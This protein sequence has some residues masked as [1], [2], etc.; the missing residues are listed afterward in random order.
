MLYDGCTLGDLAVNALGRY[1]ERDAVICGDRRQ[2]YAELRDQVARFAAV[3]ASAGLQPGDRVAI[4]ARN[5]PE[6]VAAFCAAYV[7]GLTL[8]PLSPHAADDDLV[9]VLQDA[10]I[11]CLLIDEIGIGERGAALAR[12]VASLRQVFTF[13]AAAFGRSLFACAAEVTPQ[14]LRSVALPDRPAVVGYT[15]GTTGKPKGVIQSQR[16]MVVA[17]QMMLAEWDWPQTPR[18]LLAT[19]LSHAAGVMVLPTLMKGGA[20]VMLPGFDPGAF[21]AEI[22]RS[23][24]SVTFLVPTMIYALLDAAAVGPARRLESLRTVFY[25]AAPM[26][27][28]R[29][30][31]AMAVFGPVFMQLY[32]QTEAP[33]CISTLRRDEHDL[34]RPE[35]L[36]SCGKPSAG[37]C[38]SLLDEHGKEVP[39]GA[40]GEICVRG[41]LVMESYHQRPEETAEVFRGGWLHTGDVGRFD[42]DGYLYIVDRCKDLII[43]GGLNVYPR[44]VESVLERHP[45]VAQCVVVGLPD[46]KWGEA[47]TAAVVC[48]SGHS[49]TAEDLAAFVRSEKSAL[50]AP[51]RIVF[52]ERLALTP[53]GKP[54]RAAIRRQLAAQSGSQSESQS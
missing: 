27:P 9:F 49:V 4:L 36:A 30:R 35:R 47:V 29:L 5:R 22:E 10:A 44:E 34:A 53:L 23:A 50:Y 43:T 2:S 16:G 24:V 1:P 26:A 21:L 28:E 15:G 39:T 18:M 20:I 42:D 54:D 11:D 13:G 12:R 51:K 38:V 31:Q 41:P 14:P 33:L 7:Q 17:H 32:G 3:F 40:I 46:P 19:P 6:V 8:T 52:A 45:V 48:R 37:L 25:G